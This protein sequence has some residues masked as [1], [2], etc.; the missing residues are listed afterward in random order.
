MKT[1]DIEGSLAIKHEVASRSGL[2][3]MVAAP[4]RATWRD[5]PTSPGIEHPEHILFHQ[6]APGFEFHDACEG[7]DGRVQQLG[8][9]Y[10]SEVCIGHLP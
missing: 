1:S 7:L 4:G 8:S 5:L 9:M 2:L 6:F 3:A 10:G